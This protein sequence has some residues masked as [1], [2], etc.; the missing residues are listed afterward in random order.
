MNL[1]ANIHSERWGPKVVDIKKVVF[2]VVV[3]RR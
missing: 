1:H 2:V 3:S